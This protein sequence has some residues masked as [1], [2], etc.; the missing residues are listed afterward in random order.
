MSRPGAAPALAAAAIMIAWGATPVATRLAIEDLSP[1][2]VA[3]MRTVIAGVVAAPILLVMRQ[4]LPPDRH[5]RMLLLASSLAGFVFFPILYTI[6]QRQTSAMHGGMILAALP[7]M[8][9]TYAA[10]LDRRGPTPRWLLGCG[11]ALVGE[12]AIVALRAGSG[13]KQPTVTGD[14]LIAG[15]ALIVS[16]GY[17]AGARLAARG[18]RSLATT[19][20]GVVIGA[21]L[22]VPVTPFLADASWQDASASAWGAVLYMAVV[23]SIV[24]YVVWYWALNR[25]GIARIAPIQFLQP[26][27]GLALAALILGERLTLSLGLAAIAI[28][29]G[30]AVAQRG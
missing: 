18:Y 11:I 14:L 12:I 7:I 6:G 3:I 1:L 16:A 20:W 13:G 2:S 19:F 9:G 26:F 22:V 4:R 23:T 15:S 27:S 28:L 30:V 21:L 5:G 25:G 24:G 29:V 8:T 17:V 10:L